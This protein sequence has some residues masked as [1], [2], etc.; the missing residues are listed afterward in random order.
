MPRVRRSET[1]PGSSPSKSA[2]ETPQDADAS[3]EPSDETHPP[4]P[5]S[6]ARRRRGVR[7]ARGGRVSAVRHRPRRARLPRRGRRRR[8]LTRCARLEGGQPPLSPP[9]RARPLRVRGVPARGFPARGLPAGVSTPEVSE[10]GVSTPEV[11]EPEPAQPEPAQ[12]ESARPGDRPVRAL[13]ARDR[14]PPDRLAERP[15]AA[16]GSERV[17]ANLRT[18]LE[19]ARAGSRRGERAPPSD[20]RG[21][22][23]EE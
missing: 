16:S 11:S 21:G 1:S 7:R 6:G 17:D 2:G 14:H 13:P 12:P 19:R 5:S 18:A 15:S 22:G 4:S 8:V 10:P 23:E 20:G 3:V 9:W